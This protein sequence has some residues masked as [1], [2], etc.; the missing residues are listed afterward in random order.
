MRSIMSLLLMM[1][2]TLAAHSQTRQV[3]GTVTDDKEGTPL[4]GVSVTVRGSNIGAQ[5]DTA[6]NF[7]INVPASART[8]VFSIVGFASKEVS[9]TS[10]NNYSVT[11]SSDASGLEEV[12]VVGYGTQ[13]RRDVTAA[14]SVI[15]GEEVRNAPVQSFD[16]ALGGRAA[17]LNITQPNGVLNNPPVIQIRGA[18]SI[19]GSSYPLIIVDGVTIFT[20]DVSTNSVVNNPLGSINPAD[21][22]E[23]TV[24]KDAAATAIYGSRAA[25]GVLV[26]TTKKGRGAKARVAYDTWAGWSKPFRL[27]DLLNAQQYSDMKNE[28]RANIGLPPAYFIDT[29]N[30]SPVDTRWYDHVYRTGFA[31]NH[32]ISVSGASGSGGRYYLS[33]G[34]TEQEGMFINNNFERMQARLNVDQ[35]VNNWL[36]LNGSVN[37][38]RSMTESPSTGSTPQGSFSTAGGARLALV[39]APVASPY[40]ADGSYNLLLP[41]TQNQLGLNRST[42][43]TGFYNPVVLNDLNLITSANDHLQGNVSADVKLLPG[44]TFKTLYGIDYIIVENK[45]FWNPLHGDGL[46]SSGTQD[47][48]TS[49]NDIA[50][51]SQSTWQNYLSFDRS[52]NDNHTISA[53]VGTEQI[54]QYLDRWG[55]KRSGVTDPYYSTIQGGFNTWDN[56]P[57]SSS[58]TL[59]PIVT[60]N[61]LLSYFGR[62]SYD[63]QKRYFFTASFRRDAYS[64]Y[65]PG[66]IAGK[67]GNFPGAAVGWQLS[68]EKFYENSGLSK[69]LN[70]FK[71]RAS[72]GKV[73]NTNIAN[74]GAL[75]TFSSN[76]LYGTYSTLY[77]SQ[78]GNRNL[79][80]EDN[81]KTDIGVTFGLFNDRITGEVSYYNNR[82]EDVIIYVPTPPSQGI[83]TNSILQ[84][85]AE[86]YNRG[87]EFALNASIIR[88]KDFTWTAGFNITT[89]RNEV[90][91]LANGV[92]EIVGFTGSQTGANERVNVTRVGE[93]MASI[94]T[95][96]TAGVN[97]Q[98]GQR[99]FIDGD[100]RQV[101]YDHSKAAG[102]RYTYVDGGGIAP[103]IDLA[104]DGRIQGPSL[105]K[106]FGGIQTQFT[107]KNFDLNMNLTFA[108]G[109]YIYNGT[110][111]GLRDQRFW[112]N[113][114]DVLNRWTKPGDVTNIP[115][116]IWN[117]NV[118]NGSAIQM[119]ENVEK[120]DFLKGK[121]IALGYTLPRSVLSLAGMNTIRIYGQIQNAFVITNYTGSDPEVASN[122]NNAIGTGSIS[123]G[124]DRNTAPQARTIVVGLNVI[125]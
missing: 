76:L 8:L 67:W 122:G 4:S 98:S 5:T 112:N 18:S 33:A 50:K 29:I 66:D 52:I 99:V 101:Q 14:I 38:T 36:T 86:M 114:T 49:F 20:G 37:Y 43:R 77:F 58:S 61:F 92:T 47:D 16:Q 109:H 30:G 25:A 78:A 27:P 2:L 113:H 91:K 120:G 90:T 39:N 94:Y 10:T 82:F 68:N 17:G 53:T 59:I 46:Q 102:E 108:G 71:V 105:P 19:T 79:K 115:K 110:Q 56:L 11:L 28:A 6:G 26:I 89:M 125:F 93:S 55:A 80:W 87:V 1:L 34:Y 7:S 51:Y 119:S 100:G 83:P 42:E 84:N 88:G 106:Y 65:S 22:D 69:V 75:S 104:R 73:G 63:Y 48:G 41:L 81:I 64:P 15:G 13:R 121:S 54:R 103:A 107:Y 74:F 118:S 31:H 70:S 24:L 40:R 95:V 72:Y 12:V 85:T 45:T 97:P 62:L 9:L 32:S 35:K 116:L 60:E 3:T 96:S 23:I 124:V 57:A 21:I 123:P 44:L 111:A 117:D